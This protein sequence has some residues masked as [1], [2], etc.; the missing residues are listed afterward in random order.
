MPVINLLL[1][2]S[3]PSVPLAFVLT[4]GVAMLSWFLVERPALKLKRYSLKPVQMDSH[5]E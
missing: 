5:S 4:F 3:I 2:L 1:V